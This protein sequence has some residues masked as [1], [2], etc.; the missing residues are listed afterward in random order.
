MRCTRASSASSS[1]RGRCPRRRCAPLPTAASTPRSRP[2]PSAWWTRSAT[3]TMQSPPRARPREWPR[4]AWSCTIGPKST[5]PTTTRRPP[6]PPRAST[7]RSSNSPRWSAARARAS[8]ISGGPDISGG[9]E[10]LTP[11]LPLG[12]GLAEGRVAGAAGDAPVVFHDVGHRLLVVGLRGIP[13][14][15]GPD[16]HVLGRGLEFA[17]A[18]PDLGLGLALGGQGA[19]GEKR[20]DLHRGDRLHLGIRGE[21]FDVAGL[22]LRLDLVPLR[23]L[24]LHQPL[25]IVND[26]TRTHHPRGR[27]GGAGAHHGGDQPEHQDAEVYRRSS[28]HVTSSCG[29]DASATRSCSSPRECSSSSV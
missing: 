18:L 7:P 1:A 2:R 10:P 21:A 24:D 9:P 6:L 26:V 5:A 4:R 27:A 17:P 14:A 3:W 28:D 19:L 22:E 12:L 20:G 23:A 29:V 16:R 13:E 11:H 8:S 15:L 25:T